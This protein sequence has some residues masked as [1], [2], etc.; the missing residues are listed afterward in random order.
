MIYAGLVAYKY[1]GTMPQNTSIT[2]RS[3]TKGI[4]GYAFADCD[5]LV[6]ISI[7]DS[8]V[9][10]GSEVFTGCSGLEQITVSS[11]NSNFDSRSG[12][13]AIIETATNTLIAGCKNTAIPNSVTSIGDYAF[14]GHSGLTSIS[15]PESV[16][17]ISSNAF[18]DCAGLENILVSSDNP[19]YDSRDNCNAIIETATDTLIA[20][21]K[22][23]I[24]PNS[25]TSIGGCAFAG[26]T[27]MTSVTIPNKVAYIGSSAFAGCLDLETILCK[28]PYISDVTVG[29]GAF[30]KVPSSCVLKVPVGSS[31]YYKESYDFSGFNIQE[32]VFKSDVLGDLNSDN[33]ANG[34]DLNILI[35]KLLYDSPLEEDVGACDLNGDGDVNGS[36]LNQLINIIL[37]K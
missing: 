3:N 11:A 33:R 18:T 27:N 19:N 4:S 15:I 2:L 8:I 22:N 16:A 35:S 10:I 36:D 28:I 20:G 31:Y 25:V 1:N 29:G 21:C 12:C 13:N 9:S 37:G 30:Y 24:I 7:T 5:G 23:T 26:R 6:S 34:T 14:A 17:S 32:V